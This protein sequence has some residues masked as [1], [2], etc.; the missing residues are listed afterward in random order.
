MHA[1]ATIARMRNT[2]LG[3]SLAVCFMVVTLA[4]ACSKKPTGEAAH[5]D[6]GISGEVA[7]GASFEGDGFAIAPP[8]GWTVDDSGSLGAD[9][10][11]LDEAAD[12]F[13]ANINVRVDSAG[14]LSLDDIISQS[15]TALGTSFT[16]Y[17]TITDESTTVDGAAAHRFEATLT[18]G[19]FE[20]HNLQSIVL[21]DDVIYTVTATSRD[22]SWSEHEAT[23]RASLAT[24]TLT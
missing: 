11:F 19:D 6:N 18:Q 10:V 4:S 14:G 16:D 20:L 13:Q 5:P 7:L 24:F 22:E 9:V 23:F 2:T 1:V 21:S 8:E 3:R 12:G 15:R 17:T